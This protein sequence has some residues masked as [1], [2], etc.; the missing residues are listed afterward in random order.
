MA[1]FARRTFNALCG[2]IRLATLSLKLDVLI[3]GLERRYRPDQPRAP[4]GTPEG[5]QWVSAGERVRTALAGVLIGE[6]V[7][8]GDAGLVLHCIY[9]DM[10]G[11]QRTVELNAM[12]SCRPTYPAAP[13]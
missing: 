13:L 3:G 1:R 4:K 2:E 5:G 12:V 10:L 7:G 9:L 11:R 8:L 6:R